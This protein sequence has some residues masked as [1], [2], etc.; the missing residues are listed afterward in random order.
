MIVEHVWSEVSEDGSNV[1]VQVRLPDT[2][3]G[4]CGAYKGKT[5]DITL[6]KS[7]AYFLVST[8]LNSLEQL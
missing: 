8:L 4:D 6:T 2:D 3:F 1:E 7:Q 5:L